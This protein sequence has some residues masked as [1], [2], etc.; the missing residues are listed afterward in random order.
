MNHFLQSSDNSPAA[1]DSAD[2][3]VGQPLVLPLSHPLRQAIERAVSVVGM[4]QT[5]CVKAQGDVSNDPE[6]M[7][8]M[9]SGLELQLGLVGHLLDCALKLSGE[10]MTTKGSLAEWLAIGDI[11]AAL[12][13]TRSAEVAHG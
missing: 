4:A 7:E 8:A 3:S 2:A 11:E 6:T 13:T 9:L 12:P 10:D 1:E 5:L